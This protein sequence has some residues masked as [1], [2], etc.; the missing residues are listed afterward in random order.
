MPARLEELEAAQEA[1]QAAMADPDYFKQPPEK[2]AEDG[3]RMKE[4][5]DE[6]ATAYERW[7]TLEAAS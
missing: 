7:E 2:L 3:T 6:L 4:L 1:M 5:A